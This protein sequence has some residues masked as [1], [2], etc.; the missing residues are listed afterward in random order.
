MLALED[1]SLPR[2]LGRVCTMY[3]SANCIT[4]HRISREH[5]RIVCSGPL[6]HQAASVITLAR[7]G[8]TTAMSSQLRGLRLIDVARAFDEIMLIHEEHAPPTGRETE[9]GDFCS[10]RQNCTASWR[11]QASP[12]AATSSDRRV[13]REM[14]LA[15]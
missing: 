4:D 3:N 7:C 2:I 8:G 14:R 9:H 10:F 15:G 12:C 1:D 6:L 5:L 13:G 11:D